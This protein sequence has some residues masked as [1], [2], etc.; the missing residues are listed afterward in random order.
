M[1]R[2]VFLIIR[3]EL[4][5]PDVPIEDRLSLHKTVASQ[6]AAEREVERLSGLDAGRSSRYY[7]QA[8]TLET[9]DE[10]EL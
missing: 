10:C 7:W 3:E 1:K 8:W 2:Q 6:E 9:P 5:G 4:R